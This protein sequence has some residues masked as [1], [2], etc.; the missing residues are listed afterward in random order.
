M[1]TFITH[2][3]DFI[4]LMNVKDFIDSSQ[5]LKEKKSKNLKIN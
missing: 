4:L 5:L 1:L 3:K 2:V